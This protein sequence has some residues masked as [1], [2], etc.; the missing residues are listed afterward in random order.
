VAVGELVGGISRR[1]ETLKVSLSDSGI[2]IEL[3]ANINKEIWDKLVVTCLSL[4]LCALMRLPLAPILENSE[5]KALA[6]GVL[7]EAE[8]VARAEGIDLPI[9]TAE[10]WLRYAEERVALNPDLAGSMYFDV[11]QG[12]KLELEAI[13]GAV[14]RLGRQHGVPTPLNFA[15]YAGLLPYINGRPD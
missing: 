15:V 11:M 13:N 1:L 9:A 2:N 6:L 8:A 3:R 7:N 10:R 14:V 5:S 4:G 12:R